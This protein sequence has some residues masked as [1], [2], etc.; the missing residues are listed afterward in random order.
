MARGLPGVAEQ[1][2]KYVIKKLGLKEKEFDA[3]M[4]LPPRN[5]RDYPNNFAIV[6]RLRTLANSMRAR[7]W[8]SR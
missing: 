6:Q 7:G 4:A 2:R 5:F 3:L 8:Y 1:D